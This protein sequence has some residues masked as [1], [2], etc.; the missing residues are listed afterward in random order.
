[1][2]TA[3]KKRELI[4]KAPLSV[5]AVQG[6]QLAEDGA[7]DITKLGALSPSA[8]FGKSASGQPVLAV[9]GIGSTD[10]TP[11]SDPAVSFNQDGIYR[12]RGWSIT[13]GLFDLD[14]VEL[15]RGP[16]GTLYGR[17][18]TSGS[19]NIVT[20]APVMGKLMG[21]ASIDLGNYDAVTLNG[22]V[23]VPFGETFAIRAALTSQKRDGFGRNA[24]A[25]DHFDADLTGARV[26][27]R[28][29]V[30]EALRIDLG[31][32]GSKE[33]GRGSTN[34]LLPL[35]GT[36]PLTIA[37]PTPDLSHIDR[38]A[39][40]VFAEVN[41]DT[42]FGNVT[43]LFGKRRN[44]QD[45]LVYAPRVGSLT[46][47]QQQ[48]AGSDH[49]S[50]ELRLSRDVGGF[51]WLVGLYAFDEKIF[52]DFAIPAFNVRSNTP[53]IR[54]DS[55][56]VFGQAGFALA[57]SLRAT[58]GLRYTRD[59]KSQPGGESNNA[60]FIQGSDTFDKT[61]NSTT[62]KLGLDYD[63]D[64]QTLLYASVG[65]GYKAGGYRPITVNGVQSASYFRPEKITAIEIGAKTTQLAGKLTLSVA[66]FR[67]DYRDFQIQSRTLLSGPPLTTQTLIYNA[68][69][70]ISQGAELET[71]FRPDGA[72]RLNATLGLLDSQYK[73]F[74]LATGD[75]FNNNAAPVSY[76]GR[77]AFAPR[78]TLNLGVEYRLAWAGGALTPRLQTHY[79]S[80]KNLDFRGFDVT[81]QAAFWRSDLSLSY[82]AP[83][84][85]W[86][87]AAYVRN[88]EN[89]VQLTQ[90]EP[91]GG[92]AGG[93]ARNTGDNRLGYG[94]FS[95]PRT[96]GIRAAVD[97]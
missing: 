60:G 78:T 36:D 29:D 71:V 48:T 38:K 58:L 84:R 63:L 7:Y 11:N 40:G 74:D 30:S 54:V 66:L 73:Q 44:R 90:A 89:K 26:R 41:W 13:G 5:T 65:N 82:E 22:A 6:E 97:F 77:M 16:Q 15:L 85:R 23:N 95:A 46:A 3:Q 2:I 43:Y 96:Y 17:N 93:P 88:L 12:A 1:M 87:L 83:K 64:R 79:E 80:D 39:Q 91:G 45:D 53:D 76:A 25:D 81:R 47:Y 35:N 21:N 62:V 52:Q 4:I 9:R 69:R 24:P 75:I 57:K 33:G 31:V 49:S 27:A 51:N 92:I 10:T 32:D 56:A 70:A 20:R 68:E 37:L 50:H 94:T 59:H 42:A 34:A 67:N 14:R 86:T 55:R 19:V 72:W 8:Q 18:A 61:W 28:W